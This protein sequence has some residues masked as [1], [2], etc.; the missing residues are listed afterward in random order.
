MKWV[1]VVIMWSLK[2]E[3]K[4][5]ASTR[6]RTRSPIWR[7]LIALIITDRI[8][9]HLVLLPLLIIEITIY[10]KRQMAKFWKKGKSG[11]TCWQRRRKYSVS[12]MRLVPAIRHQK[13]KRKRARSYNFECDSNDLLNP[14]QQNVVNELQK[15]Q[16]SKMQSRPL[17]YPLTV[18][19]PCTNKL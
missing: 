19:R 9:L 4:S 5:R 17:N 11:E 3:L 8:G 6:S 13:H 16:D 10:E 7:S 15:Q 12:P 14:D 1:C 18:V 2:L